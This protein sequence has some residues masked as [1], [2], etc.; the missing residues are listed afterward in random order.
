MVYHRVK[1]SLK[2]EEEEEEGEG[3]EGI[4]TEE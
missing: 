1:R 3:I 2:S 4:I